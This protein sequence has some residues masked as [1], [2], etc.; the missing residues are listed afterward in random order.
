MQIKIF[1]FNMVCVNTYL[2]HD[3][4][5][6]AV[7]VDCGAFTEKER[8]RLEEYISTN[9][10]KIKHLLNTHLHFDHT[11][12]NYFI[13]KNY[14]LKPQYNKEDDRMPSLK[15]QAASFGVRI[16]YE[17]VKAGH[18]INDGDDIH[19]GNTTLKA[20]STPGHSPGGLSFY[21]EKDH[22]V[23]TGDTLFHRDIGRTDLWEGDENVLRQAIRSQLLTLPDNTVVF[24]GH[25]PSSS[26][27]EEKQRNPYLRT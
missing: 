5:K 24:P 14:G 23:F 18:F 10:L 13:Y 1:E 8:N 4:T 11:L 20:L 21:C 7:I 19:F 17:P 2:L 9:E 12:G 26:V 27:A 25:G 16:D 22:C 3:E 6:E 15:M